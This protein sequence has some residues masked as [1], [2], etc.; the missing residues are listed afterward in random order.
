MLSVLKEKD[1]DIQALRRFYE[2]ILLEKEDTIQNLQL[3]ISS[4]NSQ[5]NEYRKQ[6]VVIQEEC[7]MKDYLLEQTVSD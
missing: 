5:I 2:S 1:E 6:L 7:T 3:Q 4:L